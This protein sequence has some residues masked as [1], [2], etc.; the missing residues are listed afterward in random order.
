MKALLLNSGLGSRMGVL[1]ENHPKCMCPINDVY[2]IISWQL[3]LLSK[4]GIKE[5]VVTT[6]PF[7]NILEEHIL[8]QEYNFKYVF[9]NNPIYKET[10]YIYSMYLARNYLDDDI[11][12][13]H[14]DLVMEPSVVADLIQQKYST[15]TV[16]SL[17]P[18]PEKDFK[19]KLKGERIN[20]IGIEFFGEDCVAC[21]PAYKLLYKDLKF[22]MEKIVEF[23]ERG[24][25]KVYA[26]SALNCILD[27][28]AL[29][30]LELNKC[31][32][33]EID[34][35]NDLNL[36]KNTFHERSGMWRK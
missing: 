15:V 12:L 17:L 30:P 33:N 16:D 4:N 18:L 23:C 21:Q 35:V 7:A 27:R 14:G 29:Y 2:T 13:F 26:E 36:I 20:A 5:V 8:S 19:A 9:V 32:C 1:T 3:E 24:E 11:L 31:L 34:N 6:G 28:I 22:W 10:N 25:T